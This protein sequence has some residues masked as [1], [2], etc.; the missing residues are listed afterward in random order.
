M[1]VCNNTVMFKSESRHFVREITDV[2]NNTV[3]KLSNDEE[4]ELLRMYDHVDKYIMIEEYGT[5]KTFTRKIR[6]ISYYDGYYI[7]TWDEEHN[8]R[9]ET[10]TK[11]LYTNDV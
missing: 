1:K 7:F 4:L 2:K 11:D 5:G 9:V 6:D 8:V 3:R 10:N